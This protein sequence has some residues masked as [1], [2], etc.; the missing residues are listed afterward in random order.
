MAAPTRL[1]PY[2]AGGGPG[3]S[4]TDT[5]VVI[6]S[7]ATLAIVWVT[8]ANDTAVSSVTLDGQTGVFVVK[9][10]QSNGRVSCWRVTGFSTGSGKT[11]TVNTASSVIKGVFIEFYQNVRATS[12]V[13][14]NATLNQPSTSQTGFT[15]NLTRLDTDSHIL[16]CVE[17]DTS[18]AVPW[19]WTTGFVDS[20]AQASLHNDAVGIANAT[21]PPS[22]SPYSCGISGAA[23]STT[24]AAVA[25]EIRG[26]TSHTGSV[27]DT[28]ALGESAP[29]KGGFLRSASDSTGLAETIAVLIDFLGSL[30]ETLGLTDSATAEVSGAIEGFLTDAL[31]FGETMTSIRAILRNRSDTLSLG[32]V[33]DALAARLAA[34]ADSL[35]LG[36]DTALSIGRQGTLDDPLSIGEQVDLSFERIGL[37]VDSLSF[38][39]LI[40]AATLGAVDETDS[41]ALA[42][43][44]TVLVARLAA[45]SDTFVFSDSIAATLA[46]QATLVDT[47]SLTS[48]RTGD[49][50]GNESG[51]LTDA[52]SL[53]D[54][55]L[56]FNGTFASRTERLILTDVTTGLVGRPRSVF[57]KLAAQP[58]NTPQLAAIPRTITLD[59]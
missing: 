23:A 49:T 11:V 30:I 18:G 37:G 24:W 22:G 35:S 48:V 53:G 32:D 27:T 38:S 19:S 52:L 7:G 15:F 25:V 12:P 13:G 10:S 4:H 56:C 39:D 47:L 46:F 3:S 20:V 59:P 40:T 54:L 14:N 2:N 29:A 26:R 55:L 21:G 36:E 8:C 43:Q 33:L 45:R 50:A 9:D 44:V 42:E 34:A 17:G 51:L 57:S 58:D 5:N 28:V 16:M 1:A 31:S 6:P 41:L